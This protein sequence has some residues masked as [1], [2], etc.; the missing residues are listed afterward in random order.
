MMSYFGAI[1]REL[2]TIRKSEKNMKKRRRNRICQVAI[3]QDLKAM[4]QKL[5]EV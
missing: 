1:K 5:G 3:E 4:G 2:D